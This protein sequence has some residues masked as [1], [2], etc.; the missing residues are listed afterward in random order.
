MR[1]YFFLILFWTTLLTLFAACKK[2]PDVTP[3][4]APDELKIVSPAEATFDDSDPAN[5]TFTVEASEGLSWQAAAS[6]ADGVRFSQGIG[7]GDGTFTL[8]EMPAGATIDLY[9]KH[10]Y[11][12]GRAQLESNRIRV[13]RSQTAVTLEVTPTEIP[14]DTEDPARNEI[15]IRSNAAWSATASEGVVFSP[16]AG[17][18][19]GTIR[20][21]AAPEGESTLTV[22]A[23]D[24]AAPVR[25]TVTITREAAQPEPD[26]EPAGDPIYRLDFGNGATGWANQM[27]SWKTQTG[28]GCEG[29][30]YDVNYVNIKNDTF[31]SSGRYEGASGGAYAMLYYNPDTDYFCVGNI[32]LPAGKTD[33]RLTFGTICRPEDLV[34][35]LSADGRR[36]Q[37][38]AFSGAPAYNTWTLAE[39]TFSLAQPVSKLYIRLVPAGIRQQYG[40]N[41]DDITLTESN[42][43]GTLIELEE[44]AADYRWPELPANFDTPATHEAVHTHWATTV[45]T[46]REVRNYTYCY[47]TQRHNPLWVAYLLHDCY[48]EGGY[49][50]PAEDPWAPDPTLDESLQSKIYPSYS[51]DNYIYYTRTTLGYGASWTRGHLVMSSERGCGDRNNPALLNVQT[52]YPTNIAPQPSTGDYTFGTA[53]GYVEALFSGTNNVGNTDFT[54]DDGAA[55]LNCVADTLF[56]VAGCHY[57]D[58]SLIEKDGSYF[59]EFSS[60]SKDCTMPTHQF[61]VALRTKQGNTGKRIQECTAS[62][63]QTIGFWI[64][65]YMTEAVT[66]GQIDRYAK[67]VAEIERLTGYTFFPEAPAEVKESFNRSEWGF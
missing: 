43:A 6:P 35:R 1:R 26:P 38:V 53:W 32:T 67:S 58:A 62:E 60:A 19:D 29:V 39:C 33:Y 51:G 37:D 54:A 63:L 16:A 42:R 18:G 49:T 7:S 48:Q 61:K 24:E 47:D 40:L 50:R 56:M 30:T 44:S 11:T 17:S 23:G 9:V 14:F 12:D 41:F 20:I 34:L 21:T 31:G 36:W 59:S 66:S 65:T 55:N 8:V 5:N 57:G 25:R 64:P 52:F 4:T 2:D 27:D 46:N 45:R 15:S 13:T 10:T 28:T 22:T 3:E